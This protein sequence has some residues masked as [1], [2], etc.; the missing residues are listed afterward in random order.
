[1][2]PKSPKAVHRTGLGFGLVPLDGRNFV[3]AGGC[4]RANVFASICGAQKH[5]SSSQPEVEDK[6]V[7]IYV[8]ER[9]FVS[10]HPNSQP[11]VD[12][13]LR[14]YSETSSPELC[15]SVMRKLEEVRMRGRKRSMFG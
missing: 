5:S 8:M 2:S 13:V 6:A 11:L 12:E 3:S 15:S 9:A 4:G 14:A 7:D 10:T 1:M